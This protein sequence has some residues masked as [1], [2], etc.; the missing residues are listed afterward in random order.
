MRAKQ[1]IVHCRG[2]S[3]ILAF[4]FTPLM[5]AGLHNKSPLLTMSKLS[6]SDVFAK[7]T[8]S[9]DIFDPFPSTEPLP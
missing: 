5:L 1:K 2:P 6:V 3:N 7:K 8:L 9:K 4:L